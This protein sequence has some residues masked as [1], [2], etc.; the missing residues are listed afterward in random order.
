MMSCQ[1]TYTLAIQIQ[2]KI[3]LFVIVILL[4][5]LMHDILTLILYL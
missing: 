4:L 2:R 3:H 1:L 5:I